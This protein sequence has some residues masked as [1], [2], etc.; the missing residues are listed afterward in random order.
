MIRVK[1]FSSFCDSQVCCDAYKRIYAEVNR[2]PSKIEYT[3]LDDYTHVVLINTAMPVLKN[4]PK[5]NVI[6]LAF[7]PLCYLGLTKKFIEYAIKNISM[8]YIG[9]SSHLPSPFVSNYSFMWHIEISRSL[10]TKDKCMSII[11]SLKKETFGQKYRHLLVENILKLGL[12]VDIFGRGCPTK[13]AGQD[14]RI[15]GEFQESEPYE[16]YN[17]TIAIE[18]V[19]LSHYVS[20]KL[21]NAFVYETTPLYYGGENCVNT[22][23]KNMFLRLTGKITEDVAFIQEIIANPSK[24]KKNIPILDIVEKINLQAHL[25]KIF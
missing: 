2:P 23:F 16:T 19:A 11:Y 13:F 14:K 21:L 7:E 1:F 17:F 18:N 8:Y 6:G 10:K 15:K 4:I 24:Y 9:D 20:E 3:N 22:K 5:K 25:E 12:N